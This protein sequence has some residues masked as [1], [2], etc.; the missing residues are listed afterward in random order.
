MSDD[1]TKAFTSEL[2]SVFIAVLS[3]MLENMQM[4]RRL[5]TL[6]VNMFKR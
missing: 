1:T 3:T 5:K 4:W 6:L 2:C